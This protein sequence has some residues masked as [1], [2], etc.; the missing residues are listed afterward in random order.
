MKR[1]NSIVVVYDGDLKCEQFSVIPH[2]FEGDIVIHGSLM[3]KGD[4]IFNGQLWV[5]GEIV[6]KGELEVSSITANSI[7]CYGLRAQ[8][9][10][11]YGD[12]RTSD[13]VVGG[14][15]N[16]T[17]CISND[18]TLDVLGNISCTELST[19]DTNISGNITATKGSIYAEDFTVGGDVICQGDIE[20]DNTNVGNN[21][22]CQG[23]FKISYGNVHIG[24][25]LSCFNIY[26]NGPYF[27]FTVG[28]NLFC[29]DITAGY[30]TV[31]GNICCKK[32]NVL[33][34]YHCQSKN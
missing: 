18:A 19:K 20:A 9:V 4:V 17:G 34:F 15:L 24:G 28:G 1:Q 14:D 26:V 30:V 31:G 32:T 13:I 27:E 21:V 25:D 10:Y 7:D 8:D 23:N 11:C 29:N 22:N 16:C 12:I 5:D 6:V 33:G 2:D 3:V